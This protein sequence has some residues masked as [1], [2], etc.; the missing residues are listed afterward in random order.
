MVITKCPGSDI[1]LFSDDVL[2]NRYPMYKRLRDAGSVVF[3]RSLNVYALPRYQDVREALSNWEVFSSARGVA[4]T[5]SVNEMIIGNTLDSDP[6]KHDQL[7]R[8]LQRPLTAPAL[9]ALTEQIETEAEK[10]VE[11]LVIKQSFDAVTDL[12][13]YLPV[14]IVSNLVGLPEEGRERMLDWASAA[15]NSLG[16]ANARCLVAMEISRGLVDYI[17]HYLTPDMLKE[18]S[19]AAMALAAARDGELTEEEARGL[20][21]DYVGPSLDTTILATASAIWLFGRNPVQWDI[22]RSDHSLVSGAIDEVL[23][24]ESPIQCFSRHVTR[25]HMIE[26]SVMPA[27]SRVLVMYGSANRDE[28][29]WQDPE[30]F[31]VLRSATDHLAFGHGVHKCVGNLLAKL[32]IKALLSALL[33]HVKHFELGV[34]QPIINNMLHGF[35]HLEVT[36]N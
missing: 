32:E 11:S 31:D 34:E 29:K 33:R 3:M 30:R 26:G 35:A 36:I 27:G 8:V 10:L 1:D 6:P 21:L 5:D 16:P 17:F 25:D 20:L 9:R 2:R 28:R 13:Q 19:W 4:L 7:R 14:S 12:A 24:L 15:F 18:N 23:R 22:M